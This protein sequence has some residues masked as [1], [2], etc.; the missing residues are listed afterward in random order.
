MGN[1]NGFVTITKSLSKVGIQG[2]TPARALSF[3]FDIELKYRGNSAIRSNSEHDSVF[4]A[5]TEYDQIAINYKETM[6]VKFSSFSSPN[7]S[8]QAFKILSSE[9]GNYNGVQQ[10]VISNMNF[11]IGGTYV[12]KRKEYGF[13]LS[14]DSKA[15]ISTINWQREWAGYRGI[16]I[17]N[18]TA[19]SL[20][21]TLNKIDNF[22]TSGHINRSISGVIGMIEFSSSTSR[23]QWCKEKAGGTNTS[24]FIGADFTSAS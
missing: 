2:Y 24:G 11:I 5:L 19:T 18:L 12:N 23:I 3:D 22:D 8:Y 10:M 4:V 14:L 9:P 15:D 20:V 6:V 13:M 7:F 21:F 16:S 17:Q 1:L